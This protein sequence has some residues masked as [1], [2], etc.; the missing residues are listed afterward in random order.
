V[1]NRVIGLDSVVAYFSSVFLFVSWAHSSASSFTPLTLTPPAQFDSIQQNHDPQVALD[2]Y[3]VL[4]EKAVVSSAIFAAFIA[5][6]GLVFFA[7]FLWKRKTLDPPCYTDIEKGGKPG[8]GPM[9]EQGDVSPE[10]P[11]QHPEK[12]P[13]IYGDPFTDNAPYGH[14]RDPLAERKPGHSRSGSNASSVTAYDSTYSLYRETLQKRA[15]LTQSISSL[16]STRRDSVSDSGH[17][18]YRGRG[19]HADKVSSMYS[20]RSRYSQTSQRITINDVRM[21]PQFATPMPPPSVALPT[22]PKYMSPPR[23]PRVRDSLALPF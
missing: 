6:I 22:R 21:P 12:S 11:M 17:L 14:Y 1:F 18:G 4:T 7:L 20:D 15:L 5:I 3:K 10:L 8:K 13:E 2:D 23:P 19:D 9:G 16:G